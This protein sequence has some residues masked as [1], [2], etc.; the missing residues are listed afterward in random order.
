MI[1]CFWITEIKMYEQL[2]RKRTHYTVETESLWHIQVLNVVFLTLIRRKFCVLT[3][4]E[5]NIKQLT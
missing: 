4:S 2:C 3:V 1:D 5:K